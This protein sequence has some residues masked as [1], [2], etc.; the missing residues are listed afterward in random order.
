VEFQDLRFRFVTV[1]PHAFFGYRREPVGELPVL[2]ADEA[3]AI[4]DSLDQP[5]Y[6]GGLAAVARSLRVAL[7]AVDVSTLVEYATRMRDKSLGSRLG[8]LLE[9][10]GQPVTGLVCSDSP[11]KLDP[12]RARSGPYVP[13]WRV[14][15][16]VSEAE[17]Q[18]AGVG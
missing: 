4:L 1:R 18:P 13:R 7:Q 11:V 17:W 3:K 15:V 2:I 8:F 5:R 16:N 10:F 12:S 9:T 6:A 14:V